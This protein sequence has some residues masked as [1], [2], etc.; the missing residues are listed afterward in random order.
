MFPRN[1]KSKVRQR[2]SAQS[3]A[4]YATKHDNQVITVNTAERQQLVRAM[5]SEPTRVY[6]DIVKCGV[7]FA[8]LASILL[9][10][11][12]PEISGAAQAA[13]GSGDHPAFAAKSSPAAA[14]RKEVFDA[15]R[16]RF[17]GNAAKRHTGET[18]L[19]THSAIVAP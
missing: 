15:R 2:Q 14:H 18:A 6:G 17:E 3:F 4:P 9:I 1:R 7:F 5:S 8:V 12:A 10:D 11:I 16:A 13:R 19:A